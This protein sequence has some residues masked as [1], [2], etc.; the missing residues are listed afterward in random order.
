MELSKIIDTVLDT[1]QEAGTIVETLKKGY[2]NQAQN[3]IIRKA[4]LVT[5]AN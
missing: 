5:I 1:Q 3:K 2:I 4:E